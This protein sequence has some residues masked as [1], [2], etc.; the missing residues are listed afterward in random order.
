[1][2]KNYLYATLNAIILRVSA[3]YTSEI[4]VNKI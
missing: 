1:M 2:I 4:T 3:L